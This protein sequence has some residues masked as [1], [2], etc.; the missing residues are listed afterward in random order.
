[1]YKFNCFLRLYGGLYIATVQNCWHRHKG[2]T[3]FVLLMDLKYERER[4]NCSAL[5]HY[6]KMFLDKCSKSG[7]C[8][9]TCLHYHKKS[10]GQT[11][12]LFGMLYQEQATTIASS[13]TAGV[14]SIWACYIQSKTPTFWD[15]PR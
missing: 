3:A 8:Q 12:R 7:V 9:L 6:K 14:L 15:D 4:I 13:T 5:T 1:M 11:G 2:L 10:V